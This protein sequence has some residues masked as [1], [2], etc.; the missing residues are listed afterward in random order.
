MI[1]IFLPLAVIATLF[2]APIYSEKVTGSESG[3][4]TDTLTGQYYVG[5]T[6]DCWIEKN[7]SL[8]GDCEPKGDL[9]GK[10]MFGAIVV[11]AIA[12]ALAIIGLI[13][14][15]GRLTSAV[16]MFAGAVVVAAIGFYLLAQMQTEGGMHAVQWGTYLAGGGGLL[17]LISGLSGMRG[18]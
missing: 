1:R 4:R 3:S 13:P 14:I 10:F 11:S 9:K 8:A 6:V 18:R 15:F 12:A 5:P 17:T 16:T 2:F 7:F